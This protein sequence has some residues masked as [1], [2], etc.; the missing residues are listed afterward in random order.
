VNRTS[1][2]VNSGLAPILLGRIPFDASGKSEPV[3][4]HAEPSGPFIVV[5]GPCGLA[6]T[7]FD[8]YQ[9]LGDSR[10]GHIGAS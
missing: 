6:T 5:R 7:F 4:G 10:V 2:S 8:F 1:L 3:F 9:I